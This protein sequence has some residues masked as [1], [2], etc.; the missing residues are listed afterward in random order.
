MQCNG[1]LHYKYRHLVNHTKL[2]LAET[3]V[4][5]IILCNM[6]CHI[7]YGSDPGRRA[8]SQHNCALLE[9]VKHVAIICGQHVVGH[10]SLVVGQHDRQQVS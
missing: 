2:T 5:N 7:S 4:K 6:Q 3:T 10:L 8:E 1:T 9:E